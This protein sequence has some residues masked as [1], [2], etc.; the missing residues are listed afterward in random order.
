MKTN[1]FLC[2]TEYLFLLSILLSV[3]KYSTGKNNIM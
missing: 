2:V 3:E 1:I